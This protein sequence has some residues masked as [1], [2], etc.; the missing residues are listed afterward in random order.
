MRQGPILLLVFV[1][2]GC[3]GAPATEG[4]VTVVS[5]QGFAKMKASKSPPPQTP[6]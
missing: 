5:T 4:K 3:G 1:L 6:K 2:S